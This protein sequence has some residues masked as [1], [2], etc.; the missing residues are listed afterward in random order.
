MCDPTVLALSSFAIKTAGAI[1]SAAAQNQNYEKNKTAAIGAET[2]SVNDINL[3][4]TQEQ[5]AAG[6]QLEAAQRQ[7]RTALSSARVS[8]G[9]AGVSGV[10]VDALLTDIGAKESVYSEDVKLNAKMTQDQLE[11]QKLGIYAQTQDRINGQTKANPF[12]TG[13]NIA[14]G[15]IGALSQL[16][17]QAPPSDGPTASDAVG[18][19]NNLGSNPLKI[20]TTYAG[21]PT[22]QFKVRPAGG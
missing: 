14:G 10:S 9:E 8:S 13:L 21:N 3:R 19:V 17:T 1:G 5:Q 20:G 22:P 15:A 7:T 16:T 2:S 6:Q 4:E 18:A 12:A 11:R